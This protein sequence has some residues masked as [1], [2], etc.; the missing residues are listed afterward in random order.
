MTRRRSICHFSVLL[1]SFVLVS[2]SDQ[3]VES[4][5]ITGST[6]VAPVVADAAKRFEEN[7]PGIRID[8]QTGGS[9]RGISDAK[10]GLADLGMVS[11]HLNTGEE[12]LSATCIAI[13]GVGLIV[14]RQNELKGLTREQVIQLYKKEITNWS[15]V[16]GTTGPVTVT[17]KADGRGTLE[18]FLA[19]TG[20]DS[21]DIKADVI[22]GGNQQAIKTVA[23]NPGAI[24]YV[25]IGAALSE[26]E[27]G[28]P[29]RLLE[30]DGIPAVPA[31]VA[32]G[33]FPI[34][35]PLLLVSGGQ[36]SPLVAEFLSYL[37][38]EE[39]RDIIESH[40]YVPVAK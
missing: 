23:G 1:I 14:H 26:I 38:S 16:G 36:N 29:I 10:S 6:T 35:R 28:T 34:T 32:Q 9:S 3:M 11:R 37:Q 24:G 39:T 8:V 30:S 27:N 15:G 33:K 22:V 40:L 31:M 12:D 7:N 5:V 17:N 13:D 4:V 2:C 20:L 18:V 21:A 25:S 19:Y